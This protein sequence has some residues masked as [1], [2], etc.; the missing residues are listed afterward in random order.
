[1]RLRHLTQP[2]SRI[3]LTEVPSSLLGFVEIAS[4]DIMSMLSE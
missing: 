2:G 1:M 4:A 3:Q